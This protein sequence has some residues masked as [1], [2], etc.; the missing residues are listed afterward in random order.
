[1]SRRG[2]LEDYAVPALR[3][4]N[5]RVDTFV[6]GSRVVYSVYQS[7]SRLASSFAFHSYHHS[8]LSTL[9]C[10][11]YS[12]QTMS[13]PGNPVP[14]PAAQVPSGIEGM[15]QQILQSVQKSVCPITNIENPLNMNSRLSTS[16]LLILSTNVLSLG[17]PMLVSNAKFVMDF[18]W[19]GLSAFV[20]WLTL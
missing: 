14:H 3:L 11:S 1:M 5:Y 9:S 19:Q 6:T 16:K 7:C 8:T 4:V 12:P 15:F 2:C 18:R 13:P 10:I 17:S 20:L